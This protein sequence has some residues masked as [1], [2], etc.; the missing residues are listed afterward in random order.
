ML[1][2]KIFGLD[3]SDGSIEVI[4]LGKTVLGKP[5]VESY[6]RLTTTGELSKNGVIKK[7]DELG[8]AIRQVLSEAKPKRITT[9]FC[10]VSLPESQVFTAVFKLPAGLRRDEVKNTLPYKAEEIIPFKAAEIYFDFMTLSVQGSTQEVFYVAVPTKIVDSYVQLLASVGLHPLALDLESVSLARSIVMQRDAKD[11]TLLMDIG[12][13]TTN[14]NI[15][16]RNGIRQGR[17][18]Q[19]AGNRF[20]KNIAAA[21]SLTPKAAA[22]LKKQVGFDPKKEQGKVLLALQKDFSKII[23]ET[24]QFIEYYQTENQRAVGR[25]IL[26]GGSSLLPKVDQYIADNLG[27]ETVLGDPLQKISD[28]QKLLKASGRVPLYANVVGL[29]LRGLA[30]N[31]SRGELNLLPLQK[32]MTLAPRKGDRRNWAQLYVRLGV[33]VLL[34]AGLMGLLLG[35]Q[36][37]YDPTATLLPSNDYT[38]FSVGGDIDYELLDTLRAKFM[39]DQLVPE[40]ATTTPVTAQLII[41]KVREVPGGK[42][43]VREGAGTNFKVIGQVSTG[44]EQAVLGEQAGWYQIELDE[45]LRGW[46]SGSYVDKLE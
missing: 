9:P 39:Q 11:A 20:T 13:R 30:R 5:R 14:L 10:V 42:L 1:K 44:S 16:D 45:G 33:F 32:R 15:F 36:R 40:Q 24:K 37:G 29:A 21:L 22:E 41:V 12:A 19:I 18:I 46:I 31:P 28:P 34:L 35:K 17:T 43:N 6:G 8:A 26:A 23:A 27:V 7:P 38:Q 25:I 4:Q 2:R 3:I